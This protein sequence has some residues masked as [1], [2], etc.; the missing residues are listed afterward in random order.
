METIASFEWPQIIKPKFVAM[1]LPLALQLEKENV[2]AQTTKRTEVDIASLV[3]HQMRALGYN[4]RI[5]SPNNMVQS[6]AAFASLAAMLAKGGNNEMSETLT[7][8]FTLY[9][10]FSLNTL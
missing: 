9:L 1:V 2:D 6:P 4:I 3:F 5:N 10:K 7:V 8:W